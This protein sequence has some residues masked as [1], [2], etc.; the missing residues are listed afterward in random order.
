MTVPPGPQTPDNQRATRAV[1]D[2]DQLGQNVRALQTRLHPSTRLMAVVKANGYGHG[3]VAVAREALAGGAKALAVATVGE[4]RELRRAGLS[5]PVLVLSP[6]TRAEIGAAL[7]DGLEL[8]VGTQDLIDAILV[9]AADYPGGARIHLKID[10]GMHRGGCDPGLAL[11]L[12]QRIAAAPA[13]HLAG[14]M[15]HFAAADEPD[16]TPTHQQAAVFLSAI[17]AL[18]ANGI[19]PGLRHCANSAATLRFPEYHFD[20]VRVGIALYGLAPSPGTPLPRNVR[21]ML[22]LESR[23]ARI[24]RLQPGEAVGYGQT[25]RASDRE[26]VGLVPIGYADGYRRGLSGQA[27]MASKGTR[28][29][30]IGRVSMDQTTVRLPETIN[31]RE[32]DRVTVLGAATGA[33]SADALAHMTD[34]INYEVVTG[35]AA[36]VPRHYIRS[37][38]VTPDNQGPAAAEP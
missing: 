18:E 14:V 24:H 37:G 35:I 34:T 17:A 20:L 11:D 3:A 25:Y 7:A 36:R 1:V 15:T 4:G 26:L 5:C 8:A 9:A 30:V 13:A 21:P 29:P 19:K 10:S 32:G 2:L 12:A 6:I 31:W 16:P 38:A 28:L 33:P 22:T 27:W 23:L